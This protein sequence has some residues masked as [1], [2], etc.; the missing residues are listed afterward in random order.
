MRLQGRRAVVTGA[1]SGL[2]EAT[3]RRFHAEG[4]RV[5]VAD[6]DGARAEAVARSLDAEGRTAASLACDIT[7][8]RQCD[9]M[10]VAAEAILG[11]PIDIFHANA[12]M[13]F[14]GGLLDA[15]DARIERAI[16]VNLTGT[17]F[18]AR[19]ALRSLVR[20][21]GVLL[22]T[23]SLQ[24]VTARPERSVYT[25]TKHAVTGLVK[26]LSLEFGPQ[27]VRVNALAPVGIDT[28]L[29]R[30]Q[31]ARSSADPDAAIAT[32]AAGL[33]L[34]RMPTQRD[35]ADAAL[36]LASDEARCITGQTLVIDCGASAGIMPAAGAAR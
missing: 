6:L 14:S 23:S 21:G 9:D 12:G 29:L 25:A 1:A 31:L 18:S 11:G 8:P 16:A 32:M 10:V 30:L 15:E 24:G 33:P 13:A 17:V 28:P 2:G 19:A 3:I 4:A 26:S 34:R 27:G 36:F 35:F 5:V 20:G 7:D 22:F